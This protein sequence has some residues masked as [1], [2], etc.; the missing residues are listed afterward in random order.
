MAMGTD[1][2]L[3]LRAILPQGPQAARDV[4]RVAPG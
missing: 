4:P 1:L 3:I 2:T